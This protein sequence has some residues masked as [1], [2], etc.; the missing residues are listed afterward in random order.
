MIPPL[1]RIFN[2][3]GADVKTW[4]AETPRTKFVIKA[5]AS[6]SGPKAIVDEYFVRDRCLVCGGPEGNG[7][8]YDWE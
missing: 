3:V 4:Y 2:L 8:E 1:E 6:D 5:K 7:G